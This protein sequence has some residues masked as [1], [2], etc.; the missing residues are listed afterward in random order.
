VADLHDAPSDDERDEL[1]A[2][3]RAAA[4]AGQISAA[5][6]D[7]RLGNVRSAQS[8]A[9]LDLMRR[10]LDQLDATVGPAAPAAPYSTFDPEDAEGGPTV[11]VSGNPRAVLIVVAVAVVVLGLVAAFVAVISRGD[12]SSESSELPPG[13]SSS[14]D[15]SS[16]GASKSPGSDPKGTYS[17]S[18]A[19]IRSFLATYQKQFHTTRVV[20]LVMYPDYAVV[21]V[22]VAG[23]RGRQQGWVY[24]PESGWIGAGG[25]RA[26]FPGA[27]TVNT[28]RLDVDALVRNIARARATLKVEKPTTTYVILRFIRRV[29]RVP[30]VDIHVANNFQESGYLA[31]RLNG[32]VERA[33]PFGG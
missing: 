22:P 17:L 1:E 14:A 32:K 3:V 29:D 20:D 16:P 23:G 6:R 13:Q 4:D 26:V 5:D 27:A 30:S 25:V 31:T 2:R 9:D 12:S 11:E 33:Y 28:R 8:R 10:D 7:I 19:G 24:R 15:P 18:A 21:D